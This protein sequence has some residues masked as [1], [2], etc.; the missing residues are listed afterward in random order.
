[1]PLIDAFGRQVTYLRISV[2]D[3]CNLRCVYCMPPQGVTWQPHD[4]ILTYEEI[5]AVVHTAAEHGVRQVR[6]TGGEPLVR[7]DLARLVRMI[8][9]T[10]GIEDLALTSNGI[11]LEKAAPALAQAGLRRVNISLD[12]LDPQRYE[13]I[14]RGGSFDMAWRGIL[15]AERLG[16]KPV[17]INMVAVRGLNDDELP[18]LARLTLEHDWEVRFIEL[19]PVMNQASWGEG[20]PAPQ[21][22]YLSVAEMLDVLH[23][24]GLEPVGSKV[25]C[26]PAQEFRLRGGLGKIG[27]ITPVGQ[28]FCQDCNRLRLTADGHLRPCLLSEREVDLR[29]AL[30][31]G[32]PLMP[33]FQQALALKPEGHELERLVRASG[34]C[35]MQIG[36]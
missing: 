19:M 11:L 18:A 30:R 15:A 35:M 13:R 6:I 25:G 10:P 17:K 33:L 16:L 7:K 26:G 5:S 31:A 32:E 24:L 1:M 23:P 27:F 4:A 9:S 3:R 21:Q 20:F 29:P 28:R 8:A 12:T 36:G 2:T 14:T 22:A 34:R